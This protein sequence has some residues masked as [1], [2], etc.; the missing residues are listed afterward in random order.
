MHSRERL[1]NSRKAIAEA[2]IGLFLGFFHRQGF[3]FDHMTS[4]SPQIC[5]YSFDQAIATELHA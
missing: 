4:Q 5:F 1:F 2:I 3:C